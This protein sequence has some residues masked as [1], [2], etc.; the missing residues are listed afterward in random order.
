MPI[1]TKNTA[2]IEKQDIKPMSNKISKELLSKLGFKHMR[3]ERTLM[4]LSIL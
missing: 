1:S 3:L 4:K 2:L